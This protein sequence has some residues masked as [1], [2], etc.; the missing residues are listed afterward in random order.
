[1]FRGGG[2]EILRVAHQNQ[3]SENDFQELYPAV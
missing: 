2:T 1:M 3:K